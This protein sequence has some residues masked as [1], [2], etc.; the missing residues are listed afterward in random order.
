MRL[1]VQEPSRVTPAILDHFAD[2]GVEDEIN[3]FDYDMAK[4]GLASIVSITA[5][6]C[7]Q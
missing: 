5:I 4:S 7:L 3:V 6:L 1:Y 2:E